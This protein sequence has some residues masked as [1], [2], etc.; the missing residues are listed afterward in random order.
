M[1]ENGSNETY[2]NV[3]VFLFQN[4]FILSSSMD[5]TVRYV[6]FRSIVYVIHKRLWESRTI[7]RKLNALFPYAAALLSLR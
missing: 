5:K 3:H 7:G 1:N 4:Y 2:D 6:S